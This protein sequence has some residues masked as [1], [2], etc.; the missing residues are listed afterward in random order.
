MI[1]IFVAAGALKRYHSIEQ[2]LAIKPPADQR[3]WVFDWAEHVL[4]MPIFPGVTVDGPT[5]KNE[6]LV[7]ATEG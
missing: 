5:E 6:S 2:I 3:Y 1:Y 4:D 7:R